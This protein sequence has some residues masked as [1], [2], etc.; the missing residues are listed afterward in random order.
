MVLCMSLTHIVVPSIR[1]CINMDVSLSNLH[2]IHNNVLFSHFFC[3]LYNVYILC[4]W[5]DIHERVYSI[6][7]ETQN[8]TRRIDKKQLI[9]WYEKDGKR[10]VWMENRR[11]GREQEQQKIA[12]NTLDRSIL[13]T[14]KIHII[15]VGFSYTPEPDL[16]ADFFAFLCPFYSGWH[17]VLVTIFCCC[18]VFR[19]LL[20]MCNSV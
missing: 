1:V 2:R 5:F 17:R 11:R 19:W 15:F 7:Y 6:Q 9:L 16:L 12:E 20:Y 13:Q 18:L 4:V 14:N 10:F 8:N 3:R